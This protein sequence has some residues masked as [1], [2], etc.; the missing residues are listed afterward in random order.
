M[1][2]GSR[3][4]ENT[5]H[6]WIQGVFM[7]RVVVTVVMTLCGFAA[8][9][10]Y[11]KDP[12][13]SEPLQGGG[14]SAVQSVVQPCKPPP[15]PPPPPPVCTTIAPVP[16]SQFDCEC[17]AQNMGR[18]GDQITEAVCGT[19]IDQAI[20]GGYVVSTTRS[21]FVNNHY[22]PVVYDAGDGT[23]LQGVCRWGC[24]AED[25]QLL[26]GMSDDGEACTTPASQLVAGDKLM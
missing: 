3:L 14:E 24:F 17:K 26:T 25:T 2:L 13:T 19:L 4:V 12:C 5:L 11:A 20:S 1:L 6:P 22:C 7:R 15:P 8:T 9:R 10:A 23:R 16:A 21:Y 18:C